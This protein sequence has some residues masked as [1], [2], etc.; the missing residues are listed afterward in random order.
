MQG[1]DAAQIQKLKEDFSRIMVDLDKVTDID[2]QIQELIEREEQSRRELI[3]YER[4]IPQLKLQIS[5]LDKI[6][7]LLK[8]EKNCAKNTGALNIS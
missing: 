1:I 2:A 4:E 8:N 5:Q 7:D 6:S 3:I